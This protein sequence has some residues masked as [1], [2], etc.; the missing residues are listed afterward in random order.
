MKKFSILLLSIGILTLFGCGGKKEIRL[1][2]DSLVV[3]E[4]LIKIEEVRIAYEKMDGLTIR[5][6]LDPAL[7]EMVMR[8]F[9]FDK[10]RLSFYPKMVDISR[11]AVKVNLN[12]EGEWTIRGK[13]LKGAGSAVFMFEGKPLRLVK[14]EGD[15]PFYRSAEVAELADAPGSGSGGSNSVRVQ[16]PPSAPF[17]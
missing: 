15:N 5:K 3:K 10:A 9:I 4:A 13:G 11:S 6:N 12:W 7:A 1:S 16:I 8:G 2:P 17:N 14:I